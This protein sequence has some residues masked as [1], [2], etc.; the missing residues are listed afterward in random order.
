MKRYA[1]AGGGQVRPLA[2][3]DQLQ[4]GKLRPF[5]V[6]LDRLTDATGLGPEQYATRRAERTNAA[7]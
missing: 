7:L 1:L 4:L 6:Q 3:W 2:H 5:A